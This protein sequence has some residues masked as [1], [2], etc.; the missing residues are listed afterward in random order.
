MI[1]YSLKSL[2][3]GESMDFNTALKKY[4]CYLVNLKINDIYDLYYYLNKLD[5]YGCGE[6]FEIEKYNPYYTKEEIKIEIS[7]RNKTML[8]W[9]DRNKC[10][11]KKFD[12]VLYDQ[13]QVWKERLTR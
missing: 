5:I 8:S 12:G 4:K 11:N 1:C 3:S 13:L 2:I 7:D 9:S 10:V 6:C